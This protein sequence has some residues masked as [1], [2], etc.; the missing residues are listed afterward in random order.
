MTPE[1]RAALEASIEKWERNAS[2]AHWADVKLQAADCPLCQLFHPEFTAFMNGECS[3]C[4][5]KD[6]TGEPFC[7]STPY[8][9]ASRLKIGWHGGKTTAEQFHKAAQAEV[10]FLRSLL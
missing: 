8:G 10:D 2:A 6:E 1:V 5:V 7:R 3:G 9:E 4:P